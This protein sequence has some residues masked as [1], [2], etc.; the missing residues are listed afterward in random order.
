MCVAHLGRA[1]P[2]PTWATARAS[3]L[4]VALGRRGPEAPR[5][6]G[7]HPRGARTLLAADVPRHLRRQ[8]PPVRLRRAPAHPRAHADC[9]GVMAVYK[10]DGRWDAVERRH[11]PGGAWVLRYEKGQ[12]RPRLRPH[13]LRRDGPA[14]RASSPR[15]RPAKPAGSTPS[16]ASSRSGSACGPAWPVRGFSKSARP[17]GWRSSITHLQN[18]SVTTM[19]VSRAPVRFSLGGGG[20]DLPS[21]SREHGGFVVA[22]AV[23]KFVFVCVARRFQ[24]NI[25]L[26][27]SESEIVDSVDQI[28]HRIFTRGA[29]MTGI[30]RGPRAAQPGR[31]AGEHRPR[32][33]EQ[34]HGRAAQRPP[35]LQ[36]RVRPRRAARAR[37]VPA[38][39]RHPQGADRQAGPVHRGLRRH[40]RDDVP[41]RRLRRRRAPARCATR[42]S[43]SSSRTSS[44]TTRASSARRRRCSR[45]RRRRSSRTRTPPSSACT[46]S[47]SSAT[48][49]SASS[50]RARSTRTARCSTST[51]RTSASSPSNMADSA[52]D[53]HYEAARKAGAIGGKLMGAGGGGFFMFYVR[54]ARAPARARALVGARPAPACA[55]AS[56]STARASWPTSTGRDETPSP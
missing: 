56:T 13:R 1:D 48:R 12:T 28:Q 8:L 7:R 21:Y 34:L 40:Q 17:K 31:R 45:S 51:G 49:R 37:G 26:A 36:A 54:A 47:R 15:C 27:Y 18:E 10:N 33:V 5:H 46:A 11:R 29:Q 2:R 23:D 20:T 55:S 44:S 6:G 16:S 35:R 14:A 32:L 22:A 30:E 53:E 41:P 52:I 43:T 19:I 42:S 25:R 9:D 50:S 4:R 39:D 24:N 3:A 38:R